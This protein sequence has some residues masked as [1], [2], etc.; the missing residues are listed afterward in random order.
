MTQQEESLTESPKS[1]AADAGDSDRGD[2]VDADAKA[3]LESARREAEENRDRYL[4]AA[5]E[6][7]N[8]R[9]RAQRDVERVHKYGLE[10]FAGELLTV[11]DSLEMGLA[12]GAAEEATVETLREGTVVTLKQLDG[13]LEKFGVSEIDPAGDQFNPELH[14]AIAAIEADAEDGSVVEVIQKGY[15]INGRLIRAARVVVAKAAKD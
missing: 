1:D 3:A 15:Q 5:A 2:S 8:V 14:E 9:K 13:V 11:R 6:L 12:A 4:R 7:D 10:K